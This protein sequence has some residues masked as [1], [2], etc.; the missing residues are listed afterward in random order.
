MPGLWESAR[1]QH[2]ALVEAIERRDAQA[3]HDLALQHFE[4]ARDIRLS[5]FAAEQ[6]R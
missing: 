2:R 1:E 6:L 4:E 3:A 5:L